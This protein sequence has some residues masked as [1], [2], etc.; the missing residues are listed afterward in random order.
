V[1]S[2]HLLEINYLLIGATSTNPIKMR[3]LYCFQR[4]APWLSWLFVSCG[5]KSTNLE[6]LALARCSR[7]TMTSR[8]PIEGLEVDHRDD[9]LQVAQ[10]HTFRNTNSFSQ[11]SQMVTTTTNYTEPKSPVEIYNQDLPDRSPNGTHELPG[12]KGHQRRGK[13]F[14]VIVCIV[15]L[16]IAGAAIGGGVGGSLVARKKKES[17]SRYLSFNKDTNRNI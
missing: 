12:E 3:L 4:A 6:T 10:Y 8:Q 9:G 1:I 16:V 13:W 2:R 15:C 7:R 5:S 17:S 14:W 11:V